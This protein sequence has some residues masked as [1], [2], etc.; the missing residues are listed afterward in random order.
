MWSDNETTTDLIGFKVHVDLIRS[1]VTDPNLLPVVLG[2]FGDWG[3]GKSSIM[4][5]LAQDLNT[6]QH[7]MER[8]RFVELVERTSY[9]GEVGLDFSRAGLSTKTQQVESFRFVLRTLHGKAKF[10]T[11]HSRQAEAAVLDILEEEQRSPVVFH[12]Y[13]GPLHVLRRAI[14]QGHF[15]SINPAM[16]NSPNGRKIIDAIPPDRVLTESDGPFVKVGNRSA[17]PA[18]VALV[19]QHLATVWQKKASEVSGKIRENF[20]EAVRSIQQ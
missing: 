11:L 13:S 5:M 17:L 8:G 7:H 12:W 2:V 18:D 3:G 16:V 14:A 19:E 6:E 10:I 20:L 15:F 4:K 1:V 9:I